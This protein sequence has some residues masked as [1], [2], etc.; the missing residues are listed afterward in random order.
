MLRLPHQ[1]LRQTAAVLTTLIDEIRDQRS[2][3]KAAGQAAA[4]RES[5]R[6]MS[7][8]R[9]L[10]RRLAAAQMSLLIVHHCDYVISNDNCAE[11]SPCLL[12]LKNLVV[13]RTADTPYQ[14]ADRLG[15]SI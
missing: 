10:H 6:M 13:E 12:Q 4:F 11:K 7:F 1:R 8:S 9:R 15:E 5:R 14:W 3:A 2:D